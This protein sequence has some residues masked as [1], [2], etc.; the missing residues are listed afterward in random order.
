MALSLVQLMKIKRDMIKDYETEY[1]KV[2]VLAYGPSSSISS[3]KSTDNNHIILVCIED[4]IIIGI[5]SATVLDNV[6][7]ILTVEI[8]PNYRHKGN[9]K[10][11]LDTF[12]KQYKTQHNKFKLTD[13]GDDLFMNN[14]T[15]SIR[16]S[17]ICYIKTFS[18]NGYNAYNNNKSSGE[19]LTIENCK[20]K[21]NHTTLVFIK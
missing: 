3:M 11:L 21:I 19:P 10:K 1:I 15:K 5:L 8:H 20:G 18:E 13:V 12:I 2:N 4:N 6:M 17:C 7:E 16:P 14:I 9:C